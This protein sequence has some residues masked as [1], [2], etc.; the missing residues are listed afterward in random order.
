M[1]KNMRKY[2]RKTGSTTV[3]SAA[4]L[5]ATTTIFSLQLDTVTLIIFDVGLFTD[6]AAK[7]AP[8]SLPHDSSSRR[9]TTS[10]GWWNYLRSLKSDVFRKGEFFQPKVNEDGDSWQRRLGVLRIGFIHV[11][12]GLQLSLGLSSPGRFVSILVRLVTSRPKAAMSKTTRF[13]LPQHPM[14]DKPKPLTKRT[15]ITTPRF[16]KGKARALTSLIGH[17]SGLSPVLGALPSTTQANQRG[18]YDNGEEDVVAADGIFLFFLLGIIAI[19]NTDSYL[20]G[21]HFHITHCYSHMS[22]SFYFLTV[23][24][25][26]EEMK[27]KYEG[28]ELRR[29]LLEA[30]GKR[31]PPRDV[32]KEKVLLLAYC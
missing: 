27:G 12:A 10:R 26:P 11:D 22:F 6:T 30:M 28:E 15:L 9:Q 4:A 32:D 24:L 19:W 18:G 17:A 2:R 31:R 16:G 7:I 3:Q 13:T 14:K 29:E 5:T 20:Y 8:V 21:S 25:G 23:L 1:F